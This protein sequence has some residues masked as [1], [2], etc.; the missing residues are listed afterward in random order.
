MGMMMMMMMMN[1]KPHEGEGDG[2]GDRSVSVLS[3]VMRKKYAY[4][5]LEDGGRVKTSA[6]HPPNPLPSFPQTRPDEALITTRSR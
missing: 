6:H 4:F 3:S 5:N 2:D 1:Y